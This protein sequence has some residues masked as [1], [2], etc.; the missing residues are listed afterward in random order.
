MNKQNKDANSLGKGEKCYITSPLSYLT[1][2]SLAD[3]FRKLFNIDE[4]EPLDVIDLLENKLPEKFEDFDWK[5]KKSIGGGKLGYIEAINKRIV[6]TE[7]T[8]TGACYDNV[9]ERFTIA[10]EI[11]HLYLMCYHGG[12]H[13]KASLC[14]KNDK[15]YKFYKDPE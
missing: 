4:H 12:E 1:I 11:A 8:Y 7:S 9:R 2:V 10:H 6:I 15:A 14:Y 3:E 13:S 5:I